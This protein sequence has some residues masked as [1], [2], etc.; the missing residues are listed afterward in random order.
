MEPTTNHRIIPINIEEEMKSSYIDYSMS[1]IV[2][3]ALPDVRDGLKPV[4]RRVL[5]GMS[6]LNLTAGASYKKSARIVGECFVPGTLVLTEQGLIPIEDI[7]RGETVY[8]QSGRAPVTELYEMPPRDLLRITLENGMSVTVT[9]SQP[10]KVLN[11]AL[12]YEWKAAKDLTPRDHVVLRA[13]YPEDLPYV[14]LPAWQARPMVL[15]EDLGYLLGLFLSDG[16]ISKSS[17]R[18]CFY[19]TSPGVIERVRE[20]LHKVFGYEARIEDKSYVYEKQGKDPVERAAFQIRI[21]AG[22]LNKYLST[23]FDIARSTLAPTKQV[24]AQILRSPKSVLAA[25][26]A[27]LFDGDGSVHDSRNQVHYGTVSEK[28]ADSVQLIMLHLGVLAKRV[29]QPARQRLSGINGRTIQGQHPFFALEANGRYAQRLGQMLDLAHEDKRARLERICARHIKVNKYDRVPYAASAVFSELSQHHRGGGWY[30][31]TE[32][33]KFR[34]GVQYST[35]TKIRYHSDLHD[36]YL[37]RTQLVDW[38]ISEKLQ[39]IGSE[40][41]GFVDDLLAHNLHFLRVATVKDAPAQ[42]TYDLQVAGLH[43][44]VAN[45]IVSHNCL[46]KYHP[47]G[48]SA[49]YDTMVRMAQDFSL[50][51]PLVDGQ[52]NFGSVDGD[53]AAAMRYTEARMTKLAEEMLRDIDKDTVDFQEN[54]DGSLEEPTV[55][56]AAVPGL[57]VNGGDGIAVGMATKIPPHNLGE[58]VDAIIAYIEHPE[59]DTKGLIEYLPGPDF[60]TGGIIY[61]HGGVY[62]AYETGRGRVIMRAKMREEEIRAG[63]LALIITEIPYQVNKSTLLEKIAG[64]ARDKRIEGIADLRDESD[65]DGMRI[66][67]ELKKDAVPLVVQNQLYKYSQCQQTFGV[68][69]VALVKGRPRVLT[70]KDCIRHYVDHRHEV[71]VRRTRSPRRR[72]HHHPPQRRHRRRPAK[73]DGRRLA[74]PAYASATR[75]P[76]PAR[77]GRLDVYALRDPGRRHPG[78]PPQ[79]PD[80]PGTSQDR[81]R[82][83]R[84]HP[85]DRTAH[86]HPGERAAPD[87]DHQRGAARPQAQVR[88]RAPHR[89]RLCRRRR[90]HH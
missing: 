60:P 31:D 83:P 76:R 61:G 32:G 71:V 9:P 75:P 53:S 19:S 65:R 84:H 64:L 35:G 33:R 16:W 44:F 6:E 2:S 24:P 5:Y 66:V 80:R 36:S 22:A 87:G 34:M 48:D 54:F 23:T 89:D 41:A 59:I 13:D 55:L 12:E 10:L 28:L 85:G 68:N 49:V 86:E 26:L 18:F 38:N 1:V 40:L 11:D 88:R 39:R 43:E 8:T 51:Y 58:V 67:V 69:T 30:E 20:A 7:E 62:Q 63:R 14:Q 81:G 29:I 77:H 15:D 25:F 73:P 82:V 57:L 17:G 37:G 47:H 27:G 78:S 79:P 45:G 42:K 3:R 74:R 46:G 4:H 70:L 52:G 50:R 72:H 21:H 56:P 90:H